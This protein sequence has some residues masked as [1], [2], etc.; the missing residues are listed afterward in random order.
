MY[1]RGISKATMAADV[2]NKTRKQ[3]I[4]FQPAGCVTMLPA[5]VE[6]LFPLAASLD[7]GTAHTAKI[8][9][10]MMELHILL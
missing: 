7:D 8:L 9:Q 2:S 10:L 6:L 5:L 4:L 3:N 1:S